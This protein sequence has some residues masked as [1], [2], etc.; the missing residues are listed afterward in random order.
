MGTDEPRDD[1]GPPALLGGA[2]GALGVGRR[3]A[4][5]LPLALTA[6]LAL[7]G[8]DGGGQ[9]FPDVGPNR[10]A[11][12]LGGGP[13]GFVTLPASEVPFPLVS[14]VQGGMHIDVSARIENIDPEGLELIYEARIDGEV[15]SDPFSRLLVRRSLRQ[16]GPAEFLRTQDL[17]F[18]QPRLRV[19]VGAPIEVSVTLVG[20][21]GAMVVDE[22]SGTLVGE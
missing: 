8:C 4:R 14:G 1:P 22:R 13:S 6:L 10:P 17:L 7:A 19:V 11:V 9:P 16:V 12:E 20:P 2:R 5:G 21:E 15:V 18:M 3:S